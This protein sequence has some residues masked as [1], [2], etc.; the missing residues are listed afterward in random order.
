[1]EGDQEKDGVALFGFQ[2]YA[3][4]FHP[5]FPQGRDNPLLSEDRPNPIDRVEWFFDPIERRWLTCSEIK[6]K[7]VLPDSYF[8]AI[9]QMSA[10]CRS[11]IKDV[12]LEANSNVMDSLTA[13][14]NEGIRLEGA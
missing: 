10:F 13:S 1:M 6:D 2:N 12:S 3:S 11:R 5:E 7:W 4:R 14:G 8:L 9:S